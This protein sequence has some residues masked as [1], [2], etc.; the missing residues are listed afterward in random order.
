[1]R[2]RRRSRPVPVGNLTIGGTAPVSV[3][4]MSTLHPAR[5]GQLLEEISRLAAAGCELIRVAVPDQEAVEA[6]PALVARSPLP[7][8]AD[9]H[10]DYRLALGALEAG[11]HKLRINPGNIG[12]ADRLALVAAAARERGIAIR[13]GVNAGSLPAVF[14]RR[15]PAERAAAMVEGALEQVRIIEGLG[16]EAIVV[17]LKASDVA[18][19]LEAN[20]LMATKGDWP[21][22]LGLTEAGSR[23]RGS[24]ASAIAIGTLLLEGIGDTIRVSLS[25]DPV[26]EVRVAW[27]ILR[28]TGI[29][30]R[31]VTVIAC[32]TCGRC[33]VEL[34]PVVEQVEKAVADWETPLTIA[35]MGCA[36]NGPGEAREADVGLAAGCEGGVIFRHGEVVGRVSSHEMVDALLAEASRAAAMIDINAGAMLPS[37]KSIG[38]KAMNEEKGDSEDYRE[39]S[40]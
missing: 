14:G 21:L 39:S 36:V 29:R 28:A 12:G 7:V 23:N 31:G 38:Q 17:A 27:D 25:T 5:A 20:R 37:K 22:H 13:V 10:F 30:Q 8:V 34:F 3:Q 16:H 6:L 2:L 35:I 4:S 11:V 15:D 32:P 19:T 9:V 40:H 1:M 26:E 33:Q 24:V 18:T